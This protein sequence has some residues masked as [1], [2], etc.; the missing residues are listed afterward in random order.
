M[1]E[2]SSFFCA[3]CEKQ[4]D[5]RSRFDR[6]L[7][8]SGHRMLEEIQKLNQPSTSTDTVIES[9][10]PPDSTDGGYDG[11][12]FVQTCGIQQLSDM[13]VSSSRVNHDKGS[14]CLLCVWECVLYLHF[15][16]T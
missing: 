13:D 1:A 6:H 15:Q 4:Y 7:V 2:R 10:T 16:D 8:S 14:V 11:S 12:K 9:T 3:L 5:F